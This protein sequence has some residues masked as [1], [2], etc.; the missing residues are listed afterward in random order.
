[1][2]IGVLPRLWLLCLSWL[3]LLARLLMVDLLMQLV[4]LHLWVVGNIPLLLLTGQM[5]TGQVL[6]GDM[7]LMLLLLL[8][9]RQMLLLLLLLIGVVLLLVFTCV[10]ELVNQSGCSSGDCRHD[11]GCAQGLQ[12]CSGKALS[13]SSDAMKQSI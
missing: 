6:T 1:L 10:T 3:L 2:T 11:C 9:T 13:G 7:L 5:L 8:L 12:V 4:M